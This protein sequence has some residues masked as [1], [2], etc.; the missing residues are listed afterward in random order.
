MASE[1]EEVED[2][3]RVR[4]AGDSKPDR[5]QHARCCGHD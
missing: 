1:V 4:H 5:E 3:L 2:L